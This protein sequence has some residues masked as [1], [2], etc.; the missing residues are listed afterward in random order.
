MR[1]DASRTREHEMLPFVIRP[2]RPAITSAVRETL[3]APAYGHPVHRE[4]ARG[5]GP[6]RECLSEFAVQKDDRLLFT[7]NSFDGSGC[8][9]QPGPVFI[10]AEECRPFAN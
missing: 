3:R 5:T 2:I 9:A 8:V 6:C 1:F 4:L 7:Y 10:H